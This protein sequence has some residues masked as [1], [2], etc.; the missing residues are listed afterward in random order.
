MATDRYLNGVL[1]AGNK[2]TCSGWRAFVRR[3]MQSLGAWPVRWLGPSSAT[4]LGGALML[5]SLALV[6]DGD[7]FGSEHRG[8]E[9][10]LNA[11]S[12]SWGAYSSPIWPMG[13]ARDIRALTAACQWLYG[14]SLLVALFAMVGVGAERLGKILPG[15]KILAVFAGTVAL[16]EVTETAPI[17]LVDSLGKWVV[18]AWIA[19]WAIPIGI[20]IA[21]SKSEG[22]P[23]RMA[24]LVFYLP[25]FM[26]GFALSVLF[27]YFAFGHG[28]FL[29]GMLMLWWGLVQSNQTL[30]R[31]NASGTTA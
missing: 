17:P 26:I 11:V 10:L 14:L 15:K 25:F 7:I 9:V 23:A 2:E 24:I 5:L 20:W 28:A 29:L 16:L 22:D 1:P 6:V 31:R 8:Y 13:P 21:K 18:V 30:T 12:S 4:L 19:C 27:S 3:T